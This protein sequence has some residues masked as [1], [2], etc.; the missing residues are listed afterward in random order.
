M[1]FGTKQ[2][3]GTDKDRYDENPTKQKLQRTVPKTSILNQPADKKYSS[4]QRK[5]AKT[6]P[7]AA[8][9]IEIPNI[10]PELP[11]RN[12]R[13]FARKKNLLSRRF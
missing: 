6:D 13:D 11:A 4:L 1:K 8:N 12:R 10:L 7:F 3:D 2:V 9:V 5:Q